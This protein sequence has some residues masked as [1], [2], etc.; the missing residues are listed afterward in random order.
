M[1]VNI[2]LT[3]LCNLVARNYQILCKY[4][5]PGEYTGLHIINKQKMHKKQ[6]NKDSKWTLGVLHIG[7]QFQVSNQVYWKRPFYILM[8]WGIDQVM[9]ILNQWSPGPCTVNQWHLVTPVVNLVLLR[10]GAS[11]TVYKHNYSNYMD[12][13]WIH[14]R[15]INFILIKEDSYF[16]CGPWAHLTM[17]NSNLT[18]AGSLGKTLVENFVNNWT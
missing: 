9:I 13:Y 1:Y 17:A 15:R 3:S 18:T 16:D 10:T 2:H 5:K 6:E 11:P 14:W 8:C 12:C 7:H 4:S